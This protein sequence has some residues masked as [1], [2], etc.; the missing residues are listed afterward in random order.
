MARLVLTFEAPGDTTTMVVGEDVLHATA[1]G[2]KLGSDLELGD[3]LTMFG[4]LGTLVI[5]TITPE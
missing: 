4:N 3:S 2:E 5:A 1:D